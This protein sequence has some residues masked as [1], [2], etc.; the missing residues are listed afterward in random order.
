MVTTTFRIMDIEDTEFTVHKPENG[1]PERFWIKVF[2]SRYD[3]IHVK[4]CNKFN[5]TKMLLDEW[6]NNKKSSSKL[7]AYFYTWIID[8]DPITYREACATLFKVLV[9]I[10][11]SKKYYLSSEIY[12]EQLLC[13]EPLNYLMGV[14]QLFYRDAKVGKI[15]G[16]E[17]LVN[18][19]A[20]SCGSYKYPVISPTFTTSKDANNVNNTKTIKSLLK[21]KCYY[22]L[23][24][25]KMQ[26]NIDIDA[27]QT[28]LASLKYVEPRKLNKYNCM[29]HKRIDKIISS[30]E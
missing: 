7:R 4:F 22:Y 14:H 13:K 26:L 25:T 30:L 27:A 21:K 18:T 9:K 1:I 23:G 29:I 2:T 19:T 17:D 8:C 15:F 24:E 5:V 16:L 28:Y 6:L 12:E 20:V 3:D 10:S 11:E